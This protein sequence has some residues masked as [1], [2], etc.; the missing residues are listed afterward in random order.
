MTETAYLQLPKEMIEAAIQREVSLSMCRAL[1]DSSAILDSAV[2]AVLT[3]KVDSD[4]KRSG[5]GNGIEYIQWA[6]EVALKKAISEA[7]TLEIG[8]YKETI[9]QNIAEQLK[10][11]NSPLLS[12]LVDSMS[13]GIVGALENKWQLTV[14]YKGK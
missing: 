2:K 5:Y 9:K 13:T 4:G 6:M 1:G 3:Q 11:K 8:K 14:E 7:L 10:K 12:R